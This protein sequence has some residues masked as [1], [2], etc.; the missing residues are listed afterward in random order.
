[1]L[2]CKNFLFIILLLIFSCKSLEQ[3]NA[4][5]DDVEKE[6]VKND[7][8]NDK[9][10]EKTEKYQES[11]YESINFNKIKEFSPLFNSRRI[12]CIPGQD[13][14]FDKGTIILFKTRD[15][16]FGKLEILNKSTLDDFMSFKY[17][18]YNYNGHV[19]FNSELSSVDFTGE[20]NFRYND[21]NSRFSDFRCELTKY[22]KGED[23]GVSIYLNPMNG[24]SFLVYKENISKEDYMKSL[25]KKIISKKTRTNFHKDSFQEYNKKVL[26]VSNRNNEIYSITFDGKKSFLFTGSEIEIFNSHIYVVDGRYIKEYSNDMKLINEIKIPSQIEA[27]VHFSIIPNIGFAFFNNGSDSISFVDSEGVYWGRIN[28]PGKK[29]FDL[30]SIDTIIIDNLLFVSSTDNNEIFTINLDDLSTEIYKKLNTLDGPSIG[31]IYYY[32][33]NFYVTNF[34][35]FFI[36]TKSETPRH[37]YGSFEPNLVDFIIVDDYIYAAINFKN[38]IIKIDMYDGSTEILNDEVFWPEEIEIFYY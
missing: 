26:L 35:D 13:N 27:I 34:T 15:M 7:I 10:E 5:P 36:F 18:L 8:L 1:M 21:S 32:D 37:K 22:N 20:F 33:N 4:I 9:V 17:T 12:N 19:V 14:E 30:Q 38:K 29:S 6:Q 16:Q 2:K 24:S 11:I 23:G 31:S 25:Y 28:M 3:R